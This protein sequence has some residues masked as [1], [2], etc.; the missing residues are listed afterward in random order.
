M[1]GKS[2]KQPRRH[3]SVRPDSTFKRNN[4][5]LSSSQREQR[6]RQQAQ[7]DRQLSL[8]QKIEK[9]RRRFRLYLVIALMIVVL[10]GYRLMIGGVKIESSQVIPSEK[11]QE[12]AAFIQKTM[13]ENS[14]ARQVWTVDKQALSTEVQSEFGE[15]Q[16]ITLNQVALLQSDVKAE[17]SF[18]QPVFIWKDA[19]ENARFLDENG[20]LFDVNYTKEDAKKLPVIE[21]GSGLVFDAGTT[22]VSKKTQEFIGALPGAMGGSVLPGIKSP[23]KF[24]KITI[25]QSVRELYVYPKNAKFFIKFETSRGVEEQVSELSSLLKF[26]KK[27]NITP[28]QYVDVR[29]EGKAF[30]K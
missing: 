27:K 20:I 12:Y 18:R 30:Y 23:S 24:S 28:S 14:L 13:I 15:V 7:T 16:S 25:P 22:V 29:L 26:L 10:L 3:S 9:H 17:L 21:D 4:A 2:K 5:A 1:L 8:Q 19:S 11:Q 6:A